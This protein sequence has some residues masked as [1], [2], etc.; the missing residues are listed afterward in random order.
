MEKWLQD[1]TAGTNAPRHQAS[2]GDVNFEKFLAE[3][4]EAVDKMPK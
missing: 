4:A 3:R 1:Q 2:G